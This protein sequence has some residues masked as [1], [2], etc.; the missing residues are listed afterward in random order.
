MSEAWKRGEAAKG[1]GEPRDMPWV[2]TRAGGFFFVNAV[3]VAPEILVLIPWTV[4]ATLRALG[5]LHGTS[6]FIDPIPEAAAYFLPWIGWGL[7]IPIWTTLKNLRMDV[8]PWARRG[9]Y[10]MLAL[11]LSFL[12][13]T[14]WSW[15]GPGVR[16]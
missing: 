7:V 1:A 13:Y 15:I 14:V 8:K 5:L 9:L 4:G 2:E 6:Q 3:L 16:G 10:V 12:A 11:H